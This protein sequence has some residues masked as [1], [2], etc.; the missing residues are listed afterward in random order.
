[1]RKRVFSSGQWQ[2]YR[3]RCQIAD[4][5]PPPVG[6]GPTPIGRVISGI[7]KSLDKPVPAWFRDIT[8][9][10]TSLAGATEAKHARPGRYEDGTLTV[11][12]DGAVWLNELKRY[13]RLEM[14]RK[15]Q[16]RFGEK[17]V[18]KLVLQPDPDLH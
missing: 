2:V 12:V 6:D 9:E 16:V 7:I 3:E 14:L 13:W 18:S 1:M 11:F 8:N 15:L 5:T 10:W 4:G 17:T